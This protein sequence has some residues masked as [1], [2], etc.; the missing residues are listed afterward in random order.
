MKVISDGDSAVLYTIHTTVPYDRNV[1]KLECT[2][3]CV[4]YY[5]SH[6]EQLVKNFPDFKGCSNLS[7]STI[8]KLLMEQGVS[9]TKD[10]KIGMLKS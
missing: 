10:P 2:N 7:K 5:R 3:H 1:S 4:K 8:I 9:F 6:L